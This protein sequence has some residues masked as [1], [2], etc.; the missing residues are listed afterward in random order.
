MNYSKK[1]FLKVDYLIENAKWEEF[2]LEESI[3]EITNYIIER[4]NLKDFAHYFELSLLLTDATYIKEINNKYRKVDKST[5]VIALAINN[6][7]NDIHTSIYGGTLMLGDIIMSFE[8]IAQEAE[9]QSKT[10]LDHFKHLLVHALLHLIGY[11]HQNDSEAEK[12]E[13]L[14]ID[15]LEKF[16]INTPYA[17]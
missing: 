12:M 2:A 10:F 16:G 5:N 3:Y 7:L 8:N 11:D 6:F 9:E 4:F 17:V 15:I 1:D 14:E 13:K